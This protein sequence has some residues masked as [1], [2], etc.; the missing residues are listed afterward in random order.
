M[1]FKIDENLS[2]VV[3]ARRLFFGLDF[4]QPDESVSRSLYLYCVESGLFPDS[5]ENNGKTVAQLTFGSNVFDVCRICGFYIG[6][7]NLPYSSEIFDA[8]CNLII[9]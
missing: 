5:K 1:T 9:E 7:T 4:I 6:K 2:R 8:F 3:N